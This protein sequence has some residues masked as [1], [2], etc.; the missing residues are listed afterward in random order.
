M[1]ETEADSTPVAEG[2]SK[3]WNPWLAIPLWLVL[4]FVA[5]PLRVPVP[6]ELK[7]NKGFI[8]LG[9]TVVVFVVGV[10]VRHLYIYKLHN[11]NDYVYSDMKMYVDLA[12]RLNQPDYKLGIGDITHPPGNTWLLQYF[13]QSDPAKL[14]GLVRLNFIVASLVPLAMG[15]LGWVAFPAK[16]LADAAAKPAGLATRILVGL[17]RERTAQVAIILGSVYFPYIDFGG[18]YLAEIHMT[19]TATLC[20]ALYLLAMRLVA[21]PE[22]VV[23]GP[24]SRAQTYR[25]ATDRPK[26]APTPIGMVAHLRATIRE[27]PGRVVVAVL[28][29]AIGGFL[30]SFAMALKMVA[31]LAIGGFVATHFFLSRKPRWLLRVAIAFVFVVAALPLTKKMVTRCTEANVEPG[32]TVGHFCTG[33]NKSAA[34]FLLG[35]KGRIQGIEW[36]DPKVPGVVGFGNPAAYQHGYREK[37]VVPFLITNQAENNKAAWDWVKKN[38]GEALVLSFE[39][40]WDSF[41]GSYPWPPNATKIW[42]FS[43]AFHFLFLVFILFPALV[44]LTDVLRDRGVVGLLRSDEFILLSPIFGVCAAVF[45]ATGEVR[46][47]IPWDPVFFLLAIEF[48]RKIT[49]R[50]WEPAPVVGSLLPLDPRPTVQAST[51]EAS[52]SHDDDDRADEAQEEEREDA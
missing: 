34:D 26:D 42:P 14:M 48:Y 30:F 37:A 29:A 11:P 44:R 27:R 24:T 46:Y 35:H 28:C 13:M 18:Y 23:E 4:P 36:R 47:R 52:A 20:I 16:K 1:S 39:H 6:A 8:W 5:A 31:M 32:E 7:R 49:Y 9:L 22:V 3:P 33:S 25:S 40:V 15:F 21:D 38:K 45:L 43:Y 2:S 10:I 12:R 17:S 41:G 19:L 51:N 50:F